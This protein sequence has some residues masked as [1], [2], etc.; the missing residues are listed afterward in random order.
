MLPQ[1]ELNSVAEVAAGTTPAAT[2]P[3]EGG[4][5]TGLVAV[6]VVVVQLP[7]QR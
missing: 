5:C 1:A 7:R 4:Q 2:Q 3:P 6:G